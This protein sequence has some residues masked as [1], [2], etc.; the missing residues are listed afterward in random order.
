M[1]EL[2]ELFGALMFDDDRTEEAVATFEQLKMFEIDCPLLKGRLEIL[3]GWDG[4]CKDSLESETQSL[5]GS[6]AILLSDLPEIEIAVRSFDSR[7]ERYSDTVLAI[8][9]DDSSELRFP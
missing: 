6:E 3:A 7:L 8:D 1:T 2:K 9:S 4:K 5:S